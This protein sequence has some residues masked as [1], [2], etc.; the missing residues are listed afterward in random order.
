VSQYTFQLIRNAQVRVL[1]KIPG[2]VLYAALDWRLAKRTMRLIA[3]GQLGA[4]LKKAGGME[5][6]SFHARR[7][8]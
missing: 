4:N 5:S 3:E 7:R 1:P 6:I 8:K 2:K